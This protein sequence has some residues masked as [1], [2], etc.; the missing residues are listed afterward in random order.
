MMCEILEPDAAS[1]NILVSVGRSADL[2][3]D[4]DRRHGQEFVSHL[5]SLSQSKL[6]TAPYSI[7]LLT[8][9]FLAPFVNEFG[10]KSGRED[11]KK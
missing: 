3:P 5:P 10:R 6:Q 8:R 11:C 4:I 9:I 1:T 2:G 7:A